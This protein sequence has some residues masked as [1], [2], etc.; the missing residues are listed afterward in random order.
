M[1]RK[2]KSNTYK[3]NFQE[4]LNFVSD[5]IMVFNQEGVVLAANKTASILLGLASE[6]LIG[7]HIE[8]LKI[9]DE[10]TKTFVKNQLQKRIKGEKIENYEIPVLVNGETRYFEPKGNRIDYFGEPAD[11]ITLRDITEKRQIH[12]QLLVKIAKMDEQCQETEEKYKKLFQQSKDAMILVN[13]KAKV[14]CWNPAAEKTFG[15]R[16]EE[17]IGKDIHKLVVP[18]TMCKEGKELISSSVKLF[19]ETGTGYFTFGNVE[20]ARAPQG[21]HRIPC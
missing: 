8:D 10:K 13:E 7:N 4:L 11:L 21:R 17:A 5:S 16:S 14:T 18:N 15:Y 3:D 19:A 2:S 9:I 20:L 1:Q 12:G 6:E